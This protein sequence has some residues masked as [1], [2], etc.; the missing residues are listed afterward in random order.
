MHFFLQLVMIYKL[1]RDN[2]FSFSKCEINNYFLLIAS[3][4]LWNFP[5]W[6]VK[7]KLSICLVF[8]LQHSFGL[9][10]AK[11]RRNDNLSTECKTCN[12]YTINFILLD[13]CQRW[14]LPV[15]SNQVATMVRHTVRRT[16]K[17]LAHE[18]LDT[19]ETISKRK[20]V[21]CFRQLPILGA[22]T[23]KLG[24][25]EAWVCKYWSYWGRAKPTQIRKYYNLNGINKS[26]F[27]PK[28][29]KTLQHM[30]RM[31]FPLCVLPHIYDYPMNPSP[32]GQV[33][34]VPRA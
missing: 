27:W 14:P 6:Y 12:L 31:L 18:R 19:R 13:N 23:E 26:G 29:V 33:Y 21:A 3:I 30:R 32:T 11:I 24:G 8:I 5:P 4:T 7:G 9:S 34:G 1:F 25:C 15:L 22:S 10:L 16:K 2:S 28:T 20:R 17:F